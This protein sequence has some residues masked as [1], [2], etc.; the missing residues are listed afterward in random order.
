MPEK[1]VFGGY[2]G[3]GVV[4]PEIKLKAGKH[5]NIQ[6]KLEVYNTLRLESL[7]LVFKLHKFL[8]NK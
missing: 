7:K 1:P 3:T 8:A 5:A 2:I 6:L 4:Q